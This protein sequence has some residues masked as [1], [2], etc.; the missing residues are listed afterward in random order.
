MTDEHERYLQLLAGYALLATD[1]RDAVE[2]DAILSDHVPTCT[3][4]RGA[5]AGFRAVAGELALAAA[6]VDPPDLVL[7]RIR[8]GI[9]EVP[10]RRR[11]GIGAAAL[12]ASVAALVGMAGLSLSLGS[13]ATRAESERGTALEV[14]SAMQ[15]P[16]VDPVALQAV[17]GST[18][19]GLV[20]LSGPGLEHMYLYGDGVPDPTPGNAYQLWLGSA[21][22]YTPVGEPFVPRGG[23]VLLR[24]TIDPS[25]YDE[26][27]IT[28]EPIGIA[29]TVPTPEGGHSWSASIAA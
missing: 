12:V 29:P 18:P 2:A 15:Q 24:L 14:L 6:P 11:R 1:G 21:G 20:E 17:S 19:G 5:L 3:T 8:R 27:V 22:S 23:V 25:R 7:A 9:R 16:G 13:R 4:C 26:V 10:V 28:E